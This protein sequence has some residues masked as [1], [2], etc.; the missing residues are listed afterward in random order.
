MSIAPIH[1]LGFPESRCYTAT[2]FPDGT[3]SGGESETE[4]VN[5]RV[6]GVRAL[7]H[8][9]F[10]L[11]AGFN[12]VGS[13]DSDPMAPGTAMYDNTACAVDLHY[14]P[15]PIL[16]FSGES[17]FTEARVE[18][19][20]QDIEEDLDG[21]AL[22]FRGERQG[23]LLRLALEYERVSPEFDNPLGSALPDREK[24]K[25][26]A[27]PPPVRQQ[28]LAAMAAGAPSAHAA[29]RAS[30]P[31]MQAALTDFLAGMI[32][33]YEA[34]NSERFMDYVAADFAG[35]KFILDAAVQDDF[36]LFENIDLQVSISH[37]DVNSGI[38]VSVGLSYARS[39]TAVSSGRVLQ[40]RGLTEMM[41]KIVDN[42]PRLYSLKNPLLFGLSDAANVASGNV[43][44]G[45]SGRMLVV[46]DHGEAHVLPFGEAMDIIRGRGRHPLTWR[47]PPPPG[48]REP[49]NFPPHPAC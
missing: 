4:V 37:F 18:S 22:R 6:C 35:D 11:R 3:P 21:Y 19:P 39:V 1:R 49:E 30:T 47:I 33:A 45:K 24:F 40:D 27:I 43:N 41:F 2:R 12:V 15:A 31:G 17:A 38:Y 23:Q 10:S 9:P 28:G 36:S 48:T 7:Y 34:Q 14:Q 25:V 32:A 26:E 5:R 46:D 44:S 13:Q 20:N 16:T 8:L 29:A 42:R